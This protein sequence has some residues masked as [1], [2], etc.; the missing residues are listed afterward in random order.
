V[1][2]C[3]ACGRESP[4]GF[5]HC[6]FCGAAL[7]APGAERRKLATLVFCDLTGS[8]ALGERVDAESILSLM[9][10][11]FE[12][13][14]GALE[15]H[16]G[17]VEKFIGD[18]VVAAFGVPEAHEDDALR[19]CRAALEMQARVDVL[20]EQFERRLGGRVAV[21]IGVNTGEVVAGAAATELVTGD[22]VNVAARLEQAAAPGDVL[23]GE[24]TVRL[25]HDAIQV[26]PVES[27]LAKGKSEP[28]PAFRLLGARG[29]GPAPRRTG[30]PFSGRD[31]QL[32][33]L[34]AAF[35]DVADRRAC[36]LVTVVGEAGVGKSRLASELVQRVDARVVRGT[37]LSY[38]E[39]IANWAIA[40]VMR[41]LAG[42]GDE[43]SREEAVALLEAHVPDRRAA[44]ATIAQL[45]GLDEGV[46]T[47]AETAWAIRSFLE[48]GA[49][50]G[51][52]LVVV[53]DVHWAEP[54]LLELLE[55]LPAAIGSA[56]VLLVCLGRGELIER[57]P[58][59]RADV[60]LEPLAGD[61]VAALVE[62][63]AGETP[64]AVRDQ[65]TRIS[66][67]NP[68]FA[69]ELVAMLLEA[70]G[71]VDTLELPTSLQALLGARLDQLEPEARDSLERGAI[72][73]ELFHRGAVVE[74]SAP[75]A[76]P[77]VPN[78]LAALVRRDF[79]RSA[80]AGFAGESAFRFKHVLVRDAA[81][82]TTAKA[83]RAELHERFADWL[84]RIAGER[85]VEHEVILGHH[86]EQS[87]R[88]R[89]ELGLLDEEARTVGDRAALLFAAA[90]H[91]AHARGDARSAAVLFG[92][93][94]ELSSSPLDRAGSALRQA[95]AL[96]EA[97]AFAEAEELLTRVRS[98]AAAAGWYGVEAG[99]DVE[100]AML[101]MYAA[102]Y[103]AAQLRTTGEHALAVFETLGDDRGMARAL[104]LLARE[105]WLATRLSEMEQL[106]DRALPA[107]E[108]AGDERLVAEV[109]QGLAQA[110]VF[111]PRPAEEAV[112]RGEVLLAR[113]REI[114]P[115][116]AATI[117]M[118]LG[119]MEAT[120][121]NRDQARK[122]GAESRRVMEEVSPGWMVAGAE[123][124]AGLASL[125]LGEAEQAETE[126]CE[127]AELL[128]QH[129]ER[130]V[131]ST[132]AALRSRALL[133]LDRHTE[134]E[135][136]ARLAL[137]WSDPGDVVSQAYAR[138]ALARLL[139]ARGAM[140]EAAAEA[141][142]AV[143]LSAASDFLNQHG[144]A[145]LDL[146]L[147]LEAAGDADAASSAAAAARDFYRAKGNAVAAALAEAQLTKLGRSPIMVAHPVKGD[148]MSENDPDRPAPDAPDEEAA[149]GA[150]FLW[151]EKEEESDE[152][153]DGDD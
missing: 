138:G 130:G 82:R 69:E 112:A 50:D 98:E 35:H 152:Q 109:L 55:A 128:A 1:S 57:H 58:D 51:P 41:E 29:F 120:R 81:Y 61:E 20:N 86:L 46:A 125:T 45:L 26:E 99:A 101:S 111:G 149:P 11:Y 110:A 88:L 144:D 119:V 140:G 114:G 92:R 153:D 37:C 19:A 36:R 54:Q 142:K 77:S 10:V 148:A 85:T 116:A 107:A 75:E 3:A 60:L 102:A 79:V 143:D 93:A 139:A 27:L 42:I 106:L 87:Y 25:L 49:R 123:L 34:E 24:A 104:L 5:R 39:G 6:G 96:R 63:L 48:A 15:R 64:P 126:L 8:T 76:R 103:S 14:R 97:L 2:T 127:A 137:E 17:T 71:D 4:D 108:R 65:L 68:L 47:P 30:T 121:G 67:G 59:W 32:Q 12:E 73:G 70:G 13:M 23:L 89:V 134:A 22:A 133:E 80:E 146:A 7:V 105:R 151:P 78:Q 100:L 145:L 40:R 131:A 84:E 62:S 91:R 132:V 136:Q 44:A 16:G 124:Y 83:L 135:Q 117:A 147:V 9:R 53:D 74:L 18:A 43:H 129:G 113:A 31:E 38:G 33:L 66:A 95:G 56:P 94:A 118:L 52:L 28:V 141:R 122:L 115:T 21:R 72:E 150:D 90:G